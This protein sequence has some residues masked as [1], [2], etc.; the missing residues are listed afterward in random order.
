[1][2][3]ILLYLTNF[4]CVLSVAAEEDV[5]ILY[6]FEKDGVYYNIH[7]EDYIFERPWNYGDPLEIIETE[8]YVTVVSK[9][10]ASLPYEYYMMDCLPYLTNEGNSYSGDV[11][12][13]AEVEF[14][15]VIYPVKKIDYGAFEK[16][17]NLKSVK[18]PESIESIE[19]YAFSGCI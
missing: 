11:V 18:L 10:S 12:I 2:K 16:C 19:P 7:T 9:E 6:D 14:E 4:F 8:P 3:R 17:H 5:R 13:P 15:G 1:M